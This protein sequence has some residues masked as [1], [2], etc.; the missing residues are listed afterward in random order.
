M[1]G[2]TM[3]EHLNISLSGMFLIFLSLSFPLHDDAN[4]YA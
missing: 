2:R 4:I 3:S 1:G